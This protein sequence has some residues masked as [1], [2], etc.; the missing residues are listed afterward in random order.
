MTIQNPKLNFINTSLKWR[1]DEILFVVFMWFLSRLVLTIGMQLIAPLHHFNPVSFNEPG[2]DTLQIKNFTPHLSW[3]LFTHWDGE[4]YRNIVN[5]GYTY[6][7][8]HK[9]NNIAFFPIYPAV[10]KLFVS[11]GIPF[12]IAGTILSNGTFLAAL[13]VFYQWIDQLYNQSVARWSTAVMAWFPL[14]LFCSLTYTESFFLFFTISALYTFENRQYGWATLWGILATA[15]R[16]PGLALIPALLLVAWL[17]HR[18]LRAYLSALMMAGGIMAFSLFCWIRFDEPM[19]FLLAQ[20]DWHQPSWI[21][22]CRD[23]IM[24]IFTI[25]LPIYLYAMAI[26]LI[27]SIGILIRYYP[28]WGYAAMGL[29]GLPVVA[30]FTA[31]LQ[32]LMPLTATWL[33]WHCRRQLNQVFLLYGWSALGFL[34]LSGTKMSIHRH[35]YAIAPLSLA[36]GLLLSRYP[37]S[38]YATIGA[39]GLLLLSYSVRIA[40]W[41]WIG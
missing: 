26:A 37:R 5:K 36:L 10:V 11:A 12:D 19:A 23:I 16:P 4:H 15:T 21:D 30:Y 20:S 22:L 6:I 33:M 32:I 31:L 17:E 27:T 2:L 34:L 3:E 7:I 8:N 39:F 25:N 28:G 24:P 40:W 9:Q 38:G 14:S 29:V 41:D 18:H 35:I 1:S 13:L